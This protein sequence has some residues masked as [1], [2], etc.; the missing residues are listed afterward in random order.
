M[1]MC[2]KCSFVMATLEDLPHCGGSINCFGT[3][4]LINATPIGSMLKLN[5]RKTEAFISMAFG[6]WWM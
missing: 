6:G 1:D 4:F 2:A 5:E 3:I